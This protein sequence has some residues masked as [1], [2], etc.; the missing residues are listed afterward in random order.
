[1]NDLPEKS[2]VG[3][4]DI[5][6][7]T[8]SLKQ[9]EVKEFNLFNKI[10]MAM[11]YLPDFKKTCRSILDGMIEEINPENC[12]VM[13][14]DPQSGELSLV[15]ASG[16]GDGKTSYH[17]FS[18]TYGK[19]FKKGEG[20]AGWVLG[21]GQA[22]IVNNV[23]ESP[24]FIRVNGC[25]QS[26]NS[27]IC[28]P[29]RDNGQVVGVLNLSHSRPDQFGEMAKIAADYVSN[30]LGAA[31]AF[32]RFCLPDKSLTQSNQVGLTSKV[33]SI[34]AL[35]PYY[36][37]LVVDSKP[38]NNGNGNFVWAGPQM[39]QIK[40]IIDQV[41]KTDVTVLIQGESGVGKE[42]VARAI[43]ENSP[44]V[45]KPFV[46]VNCAALPSEL[47][48]SELFGYAKGAF[49]G[50]YCHKPGKFELAQEGIIFLDEIGEIK[51]SLQTKLL[52]VLQDGK[53][54]RLGGK[55]EVKVDVRILA[56]TNRNIEEAVKRGL[57][58]E[59]FY[60]RL[61][62]VSINIPPL[63]DRKEEI[64]VFVEYFLNKFGNKYG[65]KI[66]T[67]SDAMMNA[68]L[69]YQW[70]GNIR[71]LENVFQRFFIFGSEKAII[72]ELSSLKTK[73]AFAAGNGDSHNGTTWPSLK[74]FNR[75]VSGKAESEI[76]MKV[77]DQTRWNRKKAADLLDI[78]YKTLLNKIKN[79][80]LC[81]SQIDIF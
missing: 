43:Y 52:Q 73:P 51:P 62:V 76:I 75:R 63:R 34:T 39:F 1:M 55:N 15:V 69:E 59:D 53:F 12:S 68:L 33:K 74:E 41:A 47:L 46:K 22:M 2:L 16:K 70:P 64:P 45:K 31:L 35:S 3:E 50:A 27:I 23:K 56:A 72:A 29:V 11:E 6:P 19:R 9:E 65:K 58:R 10:H 20:V 17:P 14:V 49:T 24:I 79:L 48:E 57:F 13:L 25:S 80:N 7:S 81:E 26:V 54:S 36:P 37:L 44:R 60:Y 21:S 5:F 4:E 8:L 38:R 42:I 71:E 28:F 77:L 78:S 30:Q 18:S 67:V 40:E 61:N 32:S 66:E